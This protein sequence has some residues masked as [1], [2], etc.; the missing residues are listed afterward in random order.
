MNHPTSS[1][2]S[3]ACRPESLQRSA[4]TLIELLVTITII[5]ALTAIALPALAKVKQS[6][7]VPR[8]LN[9]LKQL[10]ILTTSYAD[11]HRTLPTTPTLGPVSEIAAPLP[12]WNCPADLSRG[13]STS[14]SS[15]AYLASLYMDQ[16]GA[17]GSVTRV[18]ELAV[19]AYQANPKL[20]LFRD[21]FE[22][23]GHRNVAFLGGAVQV[24]HPEAR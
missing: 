23:H 14:G 6:T 8:C 5:A 20:P 10:S 21:V 4:F 11:D 16:V 24:M 13:A 1:V 22:W 2:S 18:P 19:R 9:N 12:I 3:D 7:W 17:G 15:Y